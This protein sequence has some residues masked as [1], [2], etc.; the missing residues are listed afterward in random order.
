M[1]GHF[2]FRDATD[3]GVFRQHADV[4]DIIQ[5]A[6]DAE[7]RELSNTGEE[8]ETQVRVTGFERTIKVAHDVAE[9]REVLF[10]MHH[11]EQGRIVFVDEHHH[12]T[13]RLFVG[14]A[15]DAL[16]ALVHIFLTFAT[17]IY[18]F[19][20]YQFQVQLA[21]QAFLVHVLRRTHVKTQNGIFRPFRFQPFQSQSP[22]QFSTP[23]KIGFQSTCQQR[24]TE[25]PGTAQEHVFRSGVCHAV[26]I[27]RLV[28]IQI[29]LVY[30]FRK[31]LYPYRVKSSLPF[32]NYHSFIASLQK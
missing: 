20:F 5:F 14:A 27:L 11:V 19:I 3:G 28:D 31:R 12:L 16:K 6:E 25:T 26:H 21:F 4:L 2:L 17:A 23:F 8:D 22:E 32:H 13:T 24:L 10:F 7:L 18:V 30:Y 15:D 9:N 29:I 1:G